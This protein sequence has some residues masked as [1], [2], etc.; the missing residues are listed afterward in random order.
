MFK[1]SGRSLKPSPGSLSGV[2]QKDNSCSPLPITDQ[3]IITKCCWTFYWLLTSKMSRIDE[4]SSG[5]EPAPKAVAAAVKPYTEMTSCAFKMIHALL[6]PL[7]L[8]PLLSLSTTRFIPLITPAAAFPPVRPGPRPR[9]RAQLSLE[10]NH[11]DNTLLRVGHNSLTAAWTHLAVCCLPRYQHVAPGCSPG[12]SL[13][14][15]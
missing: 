5:Y 12:T 11:S 7:P 13:T 6:P 1:Q 14:A 3:C 15:L 4:F 8:L 9:C 10:V 2:M